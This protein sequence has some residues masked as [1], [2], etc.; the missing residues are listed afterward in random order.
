MDAQT[1]ANFDGRRGPDVAC[2]AR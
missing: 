1:A 2:T